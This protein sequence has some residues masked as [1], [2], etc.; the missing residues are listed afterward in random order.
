V[1]SPEAVLFRQLTKSVFRAHNA[2]LRLGDLLNE[3]FGQSSARWRL[4]ELVDGGLGSV[5]DIARETGSSRQAVQRLSDG[6][7]ADG[8]AT[9][10]PHPTDGRRQVLSLT[11]PGAARLASVDA[12]YDAWVG[13]VLAEVGPA[14]AHDAIARLDAISRVLE[15]DVARFRRDRVRARSAAGGDARETSETR[16]DGDRHDGRRGHDGDD[17]DDGHDRD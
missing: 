3:P 4:L 12:A 9:Y 5:A 13:P 6:L 2:V 7:V 8:L 14:A 15:E 11:D 17:G 16:D 10:R 1:L